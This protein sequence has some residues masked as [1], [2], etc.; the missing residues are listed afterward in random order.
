MAND[1]QDGLID[2]E[3]SKGGAKVEVPFKGIFVLQKSDEKITKGKVQYA[4]HGDKF[5]L[6]AD[7]ENVEIR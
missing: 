1:D 5:E 3:R 4:A 7:L 2:S 6:T